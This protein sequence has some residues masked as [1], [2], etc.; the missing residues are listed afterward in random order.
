MTSPSKADGQRLAELLRKQENS[1]RRQAPI[2][3]RPSQPLPPAPETANLGAENSPRAEPP[4]P[5]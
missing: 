3:R 2:P 4:P 5:P 1:L